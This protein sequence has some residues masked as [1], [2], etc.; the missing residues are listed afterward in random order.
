[1]LVIIVAQEK[2]NQDEH[3]GF[4]PILSV[5]QERG[6]Q[7]AGYVATSNERDFNNF[8]STLVY[9]TNFRS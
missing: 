9:Q 3:K 7:I 8:I 6:R 2:H 1:M 4:S 5:V